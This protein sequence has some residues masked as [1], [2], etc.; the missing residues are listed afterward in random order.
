MPITHNFP[1]SRKDNVEITL[2]LDKSGEDSMHI[3]YIATG[4]DPVFPPDK[5]YESR[6]AMRVVGCASG[7][8]TEW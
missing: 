7:S 8:T 2:H 5:A 3:S 6:Q 1:Q 4:A